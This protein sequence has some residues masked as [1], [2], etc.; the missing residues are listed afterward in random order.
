VALASFRRD[1]SGDSRAERL[2]VVTK[3]C[4]VASAGNAHFKRDI[5][6]GWI[7]DSEKMP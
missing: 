2:A 6:D 7:A 4:F 5:G 3:S 1:Q